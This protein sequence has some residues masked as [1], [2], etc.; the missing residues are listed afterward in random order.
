MFLKIGKSIP[1]SVIKS[2]QFE[3]YL[4]VLL[5]EQIRHDTSH[6]FIKEGHVIYM[7][8][9]QRKNMTAFDSKRM[10]YSC[11][12]HS[13]AYGDSSAPKDFVCTCDRRG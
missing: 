10:L 11:G 4:H 7:S 12:I 8:R 3:T 9:V 13:C 1:S 5:K 2:Y 6:K